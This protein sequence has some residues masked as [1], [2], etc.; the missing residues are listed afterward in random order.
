MT[1][2]SSLWNKVPIIVIYTVIQQ[3]W[4]WKD[5]V[6]INSVHS[7]TSLA[8]FNTVTRVILSSTKPV[9]GKTPRSF[10]TIQYTVWT[11]SVPFEVDAF[12]L[13]KKVFSFLRKT[14]E[15][16]YLKTRLKEI[17]NNYKRLAYLCPAVTNNLAKLSPFMILSGPFELVLVSSF[18]SVK[19]TPPGWDTTLSQVSTQ[20]K[21]ILILPTSKESYEW[22]S[23]STLVKVINFNLGPCG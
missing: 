1:F 20:H 13:F 16:I 2:L 19:Q 21:L 15:S 17:F 4:R 18:C 6:N 11:D 9:A 10:F 12:P 3:T 8:A 23:K 5:K 22:K 14:K 7:F